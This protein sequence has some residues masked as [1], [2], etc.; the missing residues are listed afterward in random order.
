ME[1][2]KIRIDTDY[3]ELIGND[4]NTKSLNKSKSI[5]TYELKYT[6]EEKMK[7]EN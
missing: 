4:S 6:E 2:E 3:L 7:N 5:K 1:D